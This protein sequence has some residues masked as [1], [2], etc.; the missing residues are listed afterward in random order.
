MAEYRIVRDNFAGY[1][2]QIRRWWVPFWVQAN[3][4]NTHCSIEAAER[5]AEQHAQGCVRYLG[6]YVPAEPKPPKMAEVVR[7]IREEVGGAR[8]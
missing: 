4:C 6:R 3:F 5:W 1:E 7:L 2:V 8:E